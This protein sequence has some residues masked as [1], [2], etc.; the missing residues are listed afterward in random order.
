MKRLKFRHPYRGY[1]SRVLTASAL[2]SPLLAFAAL[3]L[4]DNRKV[5]LV[6]PFMLM[7]FILTLIL[8]YLIMSHT[9][10]EEKYLIEQA[11]EYNWQSLDDWMYTA[12][13]NKYKMPWFEI[14]IV[15][16]LIAVSLICLALTM[17]DV[18]SLLPGL[19]VGGG[20]IALMLIFYAVR[21]KLWYSIDESAE[22]TV[23]K[24]CM[25]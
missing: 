13:Q 18:G 14:T 23:L 2:I 15:T 3:F 10:A 6:L 8:A 22:Y 12:V 4:P 5:S 7:S 17:N 1:E 16:V 25:L 24:D 9:N 11:E 20:I 21:R 19:A